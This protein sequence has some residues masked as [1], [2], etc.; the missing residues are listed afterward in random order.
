MANPLT[1]TEYYEEEYERL[2]EQADHDH[3]QHNEEHAPEGE[4]EE[5][6]T[7]NAQ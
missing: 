2:R 4:E 7:P 6:S 3:K 5:G 1:F